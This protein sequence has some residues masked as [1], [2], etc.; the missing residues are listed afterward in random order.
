MARTGV[1]QAGID[2]T[3]RSPN[4]AG[5]SS[6]RGSAAT[7]CTMHSVAERMSGSVAAIFSC[8]ERRVSWAEGSKG[9]VAT[10]TT[11]AMPKSGAKIMVYPLSF[12]VSHSGANHYRSTCNLWATGLR[13]E[14][15][16]ELEPAT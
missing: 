15:E 5:F 4:A 6:W 7:A 14:A 13:P 2:A 11:H 1:T 3:I 9:P 12:L 16:L 10:G 8:A